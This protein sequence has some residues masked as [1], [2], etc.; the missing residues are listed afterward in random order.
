MSSPK[1]KKVHYERG[2][3]SGSH[4]H[5]SSRDSGIGSSSASDRASLGTAANE[6]SFDSRQIETQRHNLR[7]VQ[8]ALDAANDKIRQLE[9]GA[10]RLNALLADSN[11]ENRLLKKEKSE[12]YNRVEHL[13]DD[14]E[15]VRKSN[16]RLRRGSNRASPPRNSLPRR[17]TEAGSN[18]SERRSRGQQPTV[19]PA[20]PQP[21]PN[22]VPSPF[23]PT[24][25]TSG[26]PITYAPAVSATYAPSAISYSA[27]PVFAHAALPRRTY[28]AKPHPNDGKYHLTPL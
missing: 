16:D 19:Y 10:A 3:K 5:R 15:D 8:E 12:L 18:R 14:L 24:L 9:A 28:H 22:P 21:P 25:R 1:Q 2:T 26:L 17:E 27:A 4:H 6:S 20:A 23:L 13:K 11:K 7:A